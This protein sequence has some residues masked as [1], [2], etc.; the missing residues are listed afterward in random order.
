MGIAQAGIL[1][2]DTP[3]CGAR[4]LIVHQPTKQG[5]LSEK[6]PGWRVEQKRLVGPNESNVV[7]TCPACQAAEAEEAALNGNPHAPD[8]VPKVVLQ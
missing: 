1:I 8:G 7:V 5:I 3:N 6:K 2:C 4:E